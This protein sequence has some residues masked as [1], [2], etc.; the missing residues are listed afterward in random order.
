MELFTSIWEHCAAFRSNNG[1]EDFN[2]NLCSG[3]KPEAGICYLGSMPLIILIQDEIV[4]TNYLRM[5]IV[6]GIMM[7]RSEETLR[8]SDGIE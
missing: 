6:S 2:Q 3:L 1:S 5:T 4:V 7:S 8:L